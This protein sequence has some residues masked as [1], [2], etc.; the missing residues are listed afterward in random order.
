MDAI[1]LP[2]VGNFKEGSRNLRVLKEDIV[3]LA[4]AGVPIFGVCLG[5]QLLFEASEE[6]AGEGLTLLKGRV[7][8]LPQHVKT[9]HMGWNTLRVSEP[10]DLLEGVDEGDYFYFV[11]S[12]YVN[13]ADRNIIVAETDYG[14]NFASVIAKRNVY[15]T[16]FHPEKS[17]K[18]GGCVLLNFAGIVKK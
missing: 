1:V 18:P 17:G 10:N 7:L 6:S 13:P 4:K 2:G 8:R 5:M 11:H 14:A 12:Y 3:R 9:P 15:G 16:Q